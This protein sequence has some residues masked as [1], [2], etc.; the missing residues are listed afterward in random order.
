MRRKQRSSI[1]SITACCTSIPDDDPGTS[2]VEQRARRCRFT[3]RLS[4]VESGADPGWRAHARGGGRPTPR[5]QT[6]LCP[7]PDPFT[8]EPSQLRFMND[9]IARCRDR[10]TDLRFPRSRNTGSLGRTWFIARELEFGRP[11]TRTVRSVPQAQPPPD[12]NKEVITITP[13]TR[14]RAAHPHGARVG[15]AIPDYVR[16][17]AIDLKIKN[18]ERCTH[19]N[20][21]HDPRNSESTC[22]HTIARTAQ[23]A[24][25]AVMPVRLWHRYTRTPGHHSR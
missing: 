14:P 12:T 25:C 24:V 1:V 5:Y 11:G 23:P 2:S 18:H 4:R 9:P 21:T 20:M 16:A 13:P 17:K 6:R 7:R 3:A 19:G 10:L 22:H 15:R 8:H